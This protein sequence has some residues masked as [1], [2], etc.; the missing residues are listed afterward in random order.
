MGNSGKRFPSE[1]LLLPF[2]G[3]SHWAKNKLE[4]L[5]TEQFVWLLSVSKNNIISTVRCS[6][7]KK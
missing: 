6:G 7:E 2:K 3:L 5:L 1:L 4:A